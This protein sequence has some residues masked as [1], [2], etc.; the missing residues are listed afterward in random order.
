MTKFFI[1]GYTFAANFLIAV[2]LVVGQATTASAGAL[3]TWSSSGP[4]GGNLSAIAI[5]ESDGSVLYAGANGIYRSED[6]AES[7]SLTNFPE[8]FTRAIAVDPAD[9]DTVYIGTVAGVYRSDD[10]GATSDARN[11]GLD[12]TNVFSLAIDPD[13]REVLL[14]GT[15][16]GIFRSTNSG[17][18]WNAVSG[19]DSAVYRSIIGTG[20]GVFYAGGDSLVYKS[21]DG[22]L[23]WNESSTNLPGE[24][25]NALAADPNNP[26]ILFVGLA[27]TL[28]RSVDAG[29]SW[30]EMDGNGDLRPSNGVLAIVVDPS[31]GLIVYA[32]L[33]NIGLF[34]STSLGASW[35]RSDIGLQNIFIRGLVVDAANPS[36]LYALTNGR[37]I[38]KT[39]D[40]GGLWT[41]KPAGIRRLFARRVVAAPSSPSVLYAAS[42]AGVDVSSDGGTTW[43]ISTRMITVPRAS[44]LAVHPTDPDIAFLGVQR[45]GG[46]FYKT[47]DRGLTWNPSN[48]SLDDEVNGSAIAIDPQSPDTI[49]I[50]RDSEGVYKSTDGGAVWIAATDGITNSSTFAL[51]IDPVDRQTVYAGTNGGVFKTEDGGNLWGLRN[52]GLSTGLERAVRGLAIDPMTPSTLYLA[53]RGGLFKSVDEATS[54]QRLVNGLDGQTVFLSVAVDPTDPQVVIA[55][56]E[57][58]GVYISEDGGASF[59]SES[60]GLTA[61]RVEDFEIV[62]ADPARIYAAVAG[63]GV[64]EFDFGGTAATETPT[65]VAASTP[66]PSPTNVP[67][68]PT[69]TSSLETATPT[70]MGEDTPTPSA[71]CQGDCNGDGVVGINELIRAINISLVRLPVAE[72]S[73]VDANR[74]GTVSISELIGAVNRLL[75]GC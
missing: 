23:T 26:Q 6:G 62:P 35:N 44:S 45:P 31:D 38:F 42:E 52:D 43:A 4:D 20:A 37:G 18:A 36:T 60:A 51:V 63:Q 24:Q 3:G 2:T 32:A 5:A 74:D 16:T 47:T 67:D 57:S 66:T 12:S 30:A 75:S 65:N 72:C 13:N 61:L 29:V 48:G 11:D 71:I 56:T 17:M 49:Y 9:A 53:T 46:G 14:V 7:W 22:G 1:W 8:D 25:V 55:G 40:G 19:L 34:R 15:S 27:F 68:S 28:Y 10:G 59:T 58:A 33:P 64:A 41:P 54:W 69:P 21:T 70:A 73:A 39:T 50:G